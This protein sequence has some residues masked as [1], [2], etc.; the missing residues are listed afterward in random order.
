MRFAVS[1]AAFTS[2]NSWKPNTCSTVAVLRMCDCYNK[3]ANCSRRYETHTYLLFITVRTVEW[4]PWYRLT[5]SI[6]TLLHSLH[7]TL[8]TFSTPRA[9]PKSIA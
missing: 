6:Y 5:S 8:G 9:Y 7:Y 3:R 4:Y 2:A 1:N